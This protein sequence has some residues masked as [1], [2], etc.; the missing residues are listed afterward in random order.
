MKLDAINNKIGAFLNDT[1][2]AAPELFQL[3][4]SEKVLSLAK[5]V[6]GE[7]DNS[8]LTNNYRA[9]IQIPGH[10]DIANLP[11]HQ[12]S[13]YNNFYKYNNSIVIWISI[14]DINEEA[15]PIV[16]KKGSQILKQVPQIEYKR[17]N[18]QIVYTVPD[19]HINHPDFPEYS[20]PTKPGDVVLI[21][22]NTIHRS[23]ENKSTNNIKLS[24]Q[25]R[26]HNANKSGF[27]PHYD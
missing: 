20:I 9:R 17:P 24:I 7:K 8:I 10:D 27:L 1:L 16:F 14:S 26:Y 11:W 18:N 6:I 4:S 13:H 21:D 19:E 5:A 22:M 12:D 25:C 23:G 3:L 2:N 15:G